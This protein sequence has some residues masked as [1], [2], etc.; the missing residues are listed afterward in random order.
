MPEIKLL[1]HHYSSRVR[2]LVGELSKNLNKIDYLEIEDFG[3]VNSES[4]AERKARAVA[5]SL[6]GREEGE[7][8]EFKL[9][10]LY[11]LL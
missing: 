1:R 2:E 10:I 3:K 7:E 4:L 8:V 9:P 6:S 11:D 5:D